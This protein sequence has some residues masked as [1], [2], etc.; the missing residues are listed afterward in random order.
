MKK[1]LD[2]LLLE[3]G[4]FTS[5]EKAK[6]NIMAGNV[7][8]DEIVEYKAG[9]MIDETK[10]H[11]EVRENL[12]PYVS[13]GG[14]KLEKAIKEFGISLKDKIC[15]DIGASTGGFTDCMM[16]NGAK[17]VYSVDVGYGQLDYRLRTDERV[18]NIERTN[19][20]YMDNS[21]I[22]DRIDFASI[23]V[24]FISLDKILP[25]LRELLGDDFEVTALIKPQF[26]AGKEEVGKNGIIRDKNIH[27]NVIKNVISFSLKNGFFPDKLSFSPVK[28]QKGNIEFLIHLSNQRNGLEEHTIDSVVE[29]AWL[30]LNK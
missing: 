14:L 26:E 17:K 15:L 24:S 9:A 2:I 27:R 28:G 29:Q 11:I 21:L 23:D 5:R 13:R 18:V 20:R 25:K 10:A 4:F 8:V 6:A 12:L 7:L 16:Q 1:R 22:K 30:E 3:R 19:F